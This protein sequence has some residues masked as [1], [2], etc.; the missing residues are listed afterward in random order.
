MK[1]LLIGNPIASGGNA[2]KRMAQLECVLKDR[3]HD[4]RNYLTQYA[5]D[6]KEHIQELSRE[7]DRIVVVGGDGT[8]NEIINGFSAAPACPILHFPTGNANLLG[9]D[10]N[11]PRK[12]TAVAD[13]VENGKVVMADTGVMNHHRFIMVCGMGFDARVTEELKKI[14]T[15]KVTKLSYVMPF[16]R[17]IK[18]SPKKP[19][20]VTIDHGKFKARGMAVIVANVRNY[21]GM[22]EMA[23]EAGVSTGV[24]D[25]VIFPRENFLS[26]LSYLA[27]AMASKISRLKDVIYVK[28]ETSVCIQSEVPIPVELD[29][30]FFERHHEVLIENQPGTLPL[31]VP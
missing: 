21:A 30:D 9:H 25:V 26:L 2:G 15:G 24:L 29:G 14:R 12:T 4:V 1:V 8:F 20:N 5:G 10:L 28:A 23:D 6:G 7:M 17:A 19:L 16:F 11:L 13:L 27:V 31:I 22:C 18:T 3:G